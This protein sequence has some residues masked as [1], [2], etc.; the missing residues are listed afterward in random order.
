MWS[1]SISYTNYSYD[2][3][4]GWYVKQISDEILISISQNIDT[5]TRS[6]WIS[7]MW[8]RG[9]SQLKS[10]RL[11]CKWR[12]YRWEMFSF[13]QLETLLKSLFS[14]II[15]NSSS[16]LL[17]LSAVRRYKYKSL[18]SLDFKARLPPLSVWTLEP[19]RRHVSSVVLNWL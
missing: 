19:F 14:K 4:K 12:F 18:C 15:C 6:T 11:S 10:S 5:F 13:S 1:N 8:K 7:S 2:I 3:L 9:H 17:N 16:F